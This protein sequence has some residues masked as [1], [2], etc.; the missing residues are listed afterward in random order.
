MIVTIAIAFPIGVMTAIYLDEFAPENKLT[1]I[2]EVNINNLAAIP[3]ILFGLLGLA[4]FY[5][6]LWRGTK[7]STGG[8]YD[9]GT[10]EF[11]R[12]HRKL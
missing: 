8:W 6:L 5:Y 12:H 4:Y 2:I 3:S 1:H 7:L 10:H 11:T 9:V